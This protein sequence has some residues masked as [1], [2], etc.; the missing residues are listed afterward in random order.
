MTGWLRAWL[1]VNWDVAGAVG[2][3]VCALACL[4]A[5]QAWFLAPTGL[6]WATALCAPRGLLHDRW[7]RLPPVKWYLH[8][9]WVRHARWIA[10]RQ[11]AGLGAFCWGKALSDI[12]A[13]ARAEFVH[14]LSQL[15][16][17]MAQAAMPDKNPEGTEQ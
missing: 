5:R 1:R 13:V 9:R 10:R 8:K 17:E 14:D 15:D 12:D 2:G 6:L 16:R 11:K 3:F 4:A 7:L